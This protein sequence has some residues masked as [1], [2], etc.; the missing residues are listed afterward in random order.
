MDVGIT[1]DALT[2]LNK[3]NFASMKIFLPLVR[4]VLQYQFISN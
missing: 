2:S 4:T 3:F 1:V